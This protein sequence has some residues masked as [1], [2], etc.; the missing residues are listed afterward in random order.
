M[1]PKRTVI[2]SFPSRIAELGLDGAIKWAVDLQ[3]KYDIQVIT[4]GGA[5]GKHY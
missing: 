4:D 1:L 3:L 5:A 2:G